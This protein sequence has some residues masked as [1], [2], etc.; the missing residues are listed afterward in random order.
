[1][2][3]V[4]RLS[5]PGERIEV[6]GEACSS[7]INFTSRKRTRSIKWIC[8]EPRPLTSQKSNRVRANSLATSAEPQL[9]GLYSVGNT[10]LIL[11]PSISTVRLRSSRSNGMA[12]DI[13]TVVGR[14][15]HKGERSSSRTKDWQS[16]DFGI[17]KFAKNSTVCCKQDGLPSKRKPAEIPHL[18]PLPL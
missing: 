16:S 10:R 15:E 11:I 8:C 3:E 6:R 14:C 13:T 7:P 2:R 1:M 5:P 12:A 18:N 9:R 17:I 4:I